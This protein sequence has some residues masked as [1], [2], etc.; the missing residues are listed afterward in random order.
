MVKESITY[1]D[2][3]GIERTEDF[4]F[5]LNDMEWVRW[6]AEKG[7]SLLETFEKVG[8]SGDPKLIMETFEELIR[9]SYG[10]KSDDG[11]RFV[12]SDEISAAFMQTEAYNEFFLKLV[13]DAEAASAFVNA[14][15]ASVKSTQKKLPTSN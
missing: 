15:V 14:L 2:Y 1:V 11:K 3:N 6:D 12:K 8:H 7:G 4:Y 13:T 9:R 5:H 10:E